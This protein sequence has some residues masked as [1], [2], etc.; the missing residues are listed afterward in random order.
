MENTGLGE[1]RQSR[2]DWVG[3][4][5][6][7]F[8]VVA[9]VMLNLLK[10]GILGGTQ[11]LPLG[12]QALFPLAYLF[13]AL[14]LLA[15]GA[16]LLAPRARRVL[17]RC[18]AGLAALSALSSVLY[19]FVWWVAAPQLMYWQDYTCIGL[20]T[21]ATGF[22]AAAALRKTK[23]SMLLL[24]SCA[25]VVVSTLAFLLPPLVEPAVSVLTRVLALASPMA[26]LVLSGLFAEET[27]ETARAE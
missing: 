4:A 15:F 2:T 3:N 6:L 17:F 13:A 8:A 5:L 12:V 20:Q 26:L 1:S 22:A 24:L 25:C 11:V 7:L 16:L 19:A 9:L 10:S 23:R 14:S 18:S 21:L 27:T